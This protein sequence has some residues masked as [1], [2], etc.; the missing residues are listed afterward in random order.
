MSSVLEQQKTNFCR[1]K[2]DPE[3]GLD[4]ALKL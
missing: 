2:T 4:V 1:P 3:Y